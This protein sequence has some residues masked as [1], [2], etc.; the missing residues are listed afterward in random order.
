MSDIQGTGY[1]S[2]HNWKNL[3]TS[4]RKE[5][6]YACECGESFLHAYDKIPDI[7]EAMHNAGVKDKCPKAYTVTD[8]R[9]VDNEVKSPCRVCGSPVEHSMDYSRPTMKC[10]EFLRETINNIL[11]QPKPG[12]RNG[13]CPACGNE[14]GIMS[15]DAWPSKQTCSKCKNI[16][17][18]Y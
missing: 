10:I 7:F 1:G 6:R 18:G 9:G 14:Q 15:N 5:T 11:S 3:G 2:S 16:W 4:P 12:L 13:E 8:R 17:W